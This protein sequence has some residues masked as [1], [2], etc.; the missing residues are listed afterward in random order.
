MIS[1]SLVKFQLLNKVIQTI[2]TTAPIYF[3]MNTIFKYSDILLYYILY[4]KHTA[5]HNLVLKQLI[6]RDKEA[7]SMKKS[8]SHIV[9]KHQQLRKDYQKLIGKVQDE[10][11]FHTYYKINSRK[12]IFL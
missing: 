1:G 3:K 8:Y 5:N 10:C 12:E 4:F 7:L 11:Q 9:H 2:I 6:A